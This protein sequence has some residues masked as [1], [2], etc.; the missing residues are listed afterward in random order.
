MSGIDF[1][2]E[3]RD[4]KVA[5]EPNCYPSADD[6]ADIDN[7][8]L[9]II[10][11]TLRHIAARA[12]AGLLKQIRAV[13]EPLDQLLAGWQAKADW[14]ADKMFEVVDE[15]GEH[16]PC[17]VVMPGG[18]MLPLNHHATNGVDQARALFIVGACND[19]LLRLQAREREKQGG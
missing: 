12:I 19:A 14:P 7:N 3:A 11:T 1:A 15:P 4:L 18:S 2:R 8:A 5:I 6:G 13:D 17:Y 10:E 16:D 9:P